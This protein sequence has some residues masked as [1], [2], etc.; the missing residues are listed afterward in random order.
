MIIKYILYLLA[1]ILCVPLGLLL[2]ALMY[3]I[4][5]SG[6]QQMTYYDKNG[7]NITEKWMQKNKI[8]YSDKGRLEWIDGGSPYDKQ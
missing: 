5:I 2:G 3:T 8:R 6:K 4:L 7:Q 1:L